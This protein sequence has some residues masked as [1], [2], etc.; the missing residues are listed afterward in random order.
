MSSILSK[1]NSFKRFRSDSVNTA[2]NNGDNESLNSTIHGNSSRPKI[3]SKKSIKIFG[4]GNNQ[5]SNFSE[6]SSN[7]N[8]KNIVVR[9]NDYNKTNS[10]S[11]PHLA[12][13][14]AITDAATHQRNITR[15]NNLSIGRSLSQNILGSNPLADK[16]IHKT[17]AALLIPEEYLLL[18]ENKPT[19]AGLIRITL[20][21][22]EDRRLKESLILKD[23]NN[24]NIVTDLLELHKNKKLYITNFHLEHYLHVLE[25]MM[26][27][28]IQVLEYFIKLTSDNGWVSY[29][30]ITQ[31]KQR[32]NLLVNNWQKRIDFYKENLCI[33][34]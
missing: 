21:G 31:L 14:A 18:L 12:T 4:S 26:S 3:F 2:S 34:G 23:D 30:E 22:K 33:S 16:P 6:D 28:E 11:T 13:S 29:K 24:Y 25:K 5:S 19:E 8:N 17:E 15:T 10:V 9:L 7:K 20:F 1:S 27:L 32:L